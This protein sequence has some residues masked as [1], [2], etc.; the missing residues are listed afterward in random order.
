[1]E[2]LKK[3]KTFIHSN[4]DIAC[5]KVACEIAELIRSRNA[6]GQS[7][8]LGLATGSTPLSVYRELVR[9]HKEDDLSF[10]KVITFNLDEYWGLSGNHDQSYRFFMNQNLFNQIDIPL[11]NTHVLSGIAQN[12]YWECLAFEARILAVGGVDLWLLGIGGN[13]HIAF[14]EPG[15]D[16]DS[17]TRRV[18]LAP[19][20]IEANSDGRFFKDP[21]EVPRSALSAGIGTIRDARKVVLLATGSQKAT[22]VAAALQGPLSPKC[23]ASLLQDHSDCSFVLDEAAAAELTKGS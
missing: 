10:D 16:A 11:W 12:A 6:M 5:S 1:M 17:R 21:N 23:P 18:D 22:A 8:V 9:L 19:Q 2:Y 15:S 20:T 14:N 3:I 7:T 13:G 4:A